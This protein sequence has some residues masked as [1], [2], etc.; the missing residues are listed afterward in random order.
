VGVGFL[1]SFA[2]LHLQAISG[3]PAGRQGLV[4]G[5]YQTAVQLGGAGTLA[6]VALV[7]ESS[8][9]HA[10]LVFT[11]VAGAGLLAALAGLRV[12][13]DRPPAGTVDSSVARSPHRDRRPPCKGAGHVPRS[14]PTDRDSRKRA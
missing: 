12:Q 2:A 7:A 6:A 8:R 3:V 4:G 13:F 14:D 5:V 11:A 1:L 9:R 10:A